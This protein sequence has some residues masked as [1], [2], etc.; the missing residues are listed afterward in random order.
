MNLATTF[1]PIL[2]LS[3]QMVKALLTVSFII[4]I[5]RIF[6]YISCLISAVV[7]VGDTIQIPRLNTFHASVVQFS[8]AELAKAENYFFL[9]MKQYG[10][11]L[12][13]LLMLSG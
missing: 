11:E 1:L 8:I 2:H 9:V 7:W 3:V 12:M 5:G 4:T 10:V 13:K 6:I